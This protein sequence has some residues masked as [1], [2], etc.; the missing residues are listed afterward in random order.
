MTYL[1][2]EIYVY[3]NHII[4]AADDDED[5]LKKKETNVNQAQIERFAQFNVL[6]AINGI[7]TAVL[8]TLAFYYYIC[9]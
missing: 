9:I 5:G 1:S 8:L 2:N 3:Y 7:K 4:I 6:Q